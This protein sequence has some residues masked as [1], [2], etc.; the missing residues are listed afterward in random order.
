MV[1]WFWVGG[2]FGF[3]CW[4]VRVFFWGGSRVGFF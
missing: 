1:G 2:V 4:C 3:G